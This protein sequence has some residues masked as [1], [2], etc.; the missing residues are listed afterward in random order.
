MIFSHGY[1]RSA[2]KLMKSIRFC[3]V[4]AVLACFTVERIVSNLTGPLISPRVRN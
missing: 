1:H 3:A 4:L 2:T